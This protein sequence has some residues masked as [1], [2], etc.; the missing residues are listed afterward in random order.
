[1]P[2]Y[3]KLAIAL[4]LL[5]FL[6][7]M[8]AAAQGEPAIAE[9]E[10]ALWPEYDRPGM[11]VIYRINWASTMALPT[12]VSLRIPSAVG[13]PNAVAELGEDNGLYNVAYER[14]V[15]G[16]WALISFIAASPAA[17]L[18][19]YDPNLFGD[20]A[21]RQYGYRWPGD[22]AVDRFRV[23]VQQ[24]AQAQGMTISPSLGSPT[25][26]RDG[27]LYFG[28]DVGNF[29]ADDSFSVDVQYSK[30]TAALTVELAE[31]IRVE[32][33]EPITGDT[34]GRVTLTDALPWMVGVV[35][36]VL[37]VGGVLLFWRGDRPGPDL[38]PVV[39]R[40]QRS[41]RRRGGKARRSPEK[42]QV[43]YC[44]HCGKRSEAGDQF[45]RACGTKLRVNEV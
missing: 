13:E 15:H 11:L 29:A 24:P 17:Q 7:P 31:E 37:V 9:L 1:M 10:V 39:E 35:G 33:S 21:V 38:S 40:P 23:Q 42:D 6:V 22:Y 20:G 3:R 4:I 19:Y 43:V 34:A 44:H 12:E 30:D 25:V 8:T 28:A 27:L 16:E 45:C 5:I 36:V 32:P 41:R 18:E 14:E 2:T 26:G